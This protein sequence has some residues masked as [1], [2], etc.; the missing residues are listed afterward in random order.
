MGDNRNYGALS[1]EALE[2]RLRVAEDVCVL[3]GWTGGGE[4]SQRGDAL[5]QLWMTWA[6]MAEVDTSPDANRH[7][8]DL[9]PQLAAQRRR[10][11]EA[12]LAK[13]RGPDDPSSDA[14]TPEAGS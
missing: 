12:T 9:I 7:I 5:T 2:A 4:G 14:S 10:T 1:R 6:R 8:D 3:F 13:L 11:R